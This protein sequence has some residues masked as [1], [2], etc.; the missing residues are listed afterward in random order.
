MA[1]IIMKEKTRVLIVKPLVHRQSIDQK[2]KKNNNVS[3]LFL[4]FLEV[5][6]QEQYLSNIDFLLVQALVC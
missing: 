5:N 2:K 4:I 3:F 6:A 1:Q